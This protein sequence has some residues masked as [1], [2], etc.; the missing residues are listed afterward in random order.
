MVFFTNVCYIWK[1]NK[2]RSSAIY[3]SIR[4]VAA[5]PP[6]FVVPRSPVGYRVLYMYRAPAFYM[7]SRNIFPDFSLQHFNWSN[8]WLLKLNILKCKTV[9][10]IYLDEDA[11]VMLYKSSVRS[12]LEYA[13][14]YVIRIDLD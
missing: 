10:F 8:K 13:K 1:G 6:W 14:Q 5:P 3:I 4:S 11:F 2:R 9:N 7:Y 12:H